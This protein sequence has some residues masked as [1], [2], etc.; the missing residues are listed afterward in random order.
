MRRRTSWI[1]VSCLALLVAVAAITAKAAAPPSNLARTLDAQR[2]LATEHP[3]DPAVLNDLGNLL[4]LTGKH[5]EAEAAYRRAIELDPNKASAQFNLGLLLQQRGDLREASKLYAGAIKA[6]PGHAWAHYQLGTVQ[7]AWGQDSKAIDSYARAF[8]LDPQLAFPEVNPHVIE[9][10]L[11][12]QAMMRA[13]KNNFVVPQVP[14]VYDD[15]ARIAAMLVPAPRPAD[16]KDQ[17]EQPQKPKAVPGAVARPPVKTQTPAGS[18]VLRERDLDH[19]NASGQAAPPGA[20]RGGTAVGGV[21]QVPGAIQPS[22]RGV[23]EWNRPE[24]TIQEVPDD[25]NGGNDGTRPQP[26]ITPP[27]GGVYYR[28]GIQSTGRLNL[29]VVPERSRVGRG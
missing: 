1:L 18:T 23:R 17:A 7:E 25:L 19:G 29:Q 20:A 8:A 4:V 27:P 6:E 26:V 16:A 2:R 13:Y 24:P 15:P 5:E 21:R 22:G 10:K 14:K 11:V 9:N 12:T 28:P 3:Q